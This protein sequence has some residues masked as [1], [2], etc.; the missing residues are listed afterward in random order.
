MSTRRP[1]REIHG[2]PHMSGRTKGDDTLWMPPIGK[3]KGPKEKRK[4]PKNIGR[5]RHPKP[6]HKERY[7]G[8]EIEKIIKRFSSGGYSK[9]KG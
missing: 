3:W 9:T 8:S 2:N 5:D 1:R 6:S 7:G 4:Q